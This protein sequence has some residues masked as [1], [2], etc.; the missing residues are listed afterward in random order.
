MKR[1][2]LATLT[3][4]ELGTVQAEPHP[5]WVERINADWVSRYGVAE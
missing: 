1:L 3:P 5:S 4:E 2:L